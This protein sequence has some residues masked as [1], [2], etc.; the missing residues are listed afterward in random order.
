MGQSLP[1]TEFTLFNDVQ[2]LDS[3]KFN[4]K[5]VNKHGKVDGTRESSAHG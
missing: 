1:I 5:K 3:L 2:T 4:I